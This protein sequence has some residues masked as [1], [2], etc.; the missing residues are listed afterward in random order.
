MDLCRR[1]F[2]YPNVTGRE[3]SAP[4]GKGRLTRLRTGPAVAT[5]EGSYLELADAPTLTGPRIVARPHEIRLVECPRLRQ[6][7]GFHSLARHR[8]APCNI[9][10]VESSTRYLSPAAANRSDRHSSRDGPSG[11]RQRAPRP[12]SNFLSLNG[13][14]RRAVRI[15]PVAELAVT[16]KAPAEHPIR[17]E[18]ARMLGSHAH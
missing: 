1:R 4:F 15:R 5:P 14:W 18:T 12:R 8:R 2:R 6:S 16:S 7:F 11:T 3:R 17:S 10:T 13:H 9:R